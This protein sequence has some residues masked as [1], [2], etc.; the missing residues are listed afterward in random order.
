MST[1]ELSNLDVHIIETSLDAGLMPK[2]PL[3]YSTL[4]YVIEN[5]RYIRTVM[6][7]VRRAKEQLARSKQ[8]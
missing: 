1:H 4:R 7:Y 8:R 3:M 2:Y 6:L 5:R